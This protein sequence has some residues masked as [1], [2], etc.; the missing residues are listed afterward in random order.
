LT[1]EPKTSNFSPMNYFKIYP[2]HEFIHTWTTG[3][4]FE[5][6]MKFYKD[7]ATQEDFSKDFVGLADMR[8]G[9]LAMTPEQASQMARF[10]VDSN[11]SRARWVFLV[12]EPTATALS[13]VY[14]DIVSEQHPI[15]VA[16]TLEAASEYLGLDL[17][18][19]IED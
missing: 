3:S 18:K 8:K 13:M 15:F 6:L 14:Q 5:T 12:S 16:S 10:V 4:D 9:E 19:I 7:V 2:G 1:I 11:Y 17:E